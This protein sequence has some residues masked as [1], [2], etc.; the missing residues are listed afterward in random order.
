MIR[1]DQFM[2]Y[3]QLFWELNILQS[4][5]V[6]QMNCAVHNNDLPGCNCLLTVLF[7]FVLASNVFAC[8]SVGGVGS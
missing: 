3:N 4:E 1:L 7:S 2:Y 6:S 8:I 5:L